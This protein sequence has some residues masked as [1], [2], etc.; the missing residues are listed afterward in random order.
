MTSRVTV[1]GVVLLSLCSC[2]SST[3]RQDDPFS[4]VSEALRS[5][6]RF[7]QARQFDAFLR[8][9]LASEERQNL[10]KDCRENAPS[11]IFCFSVAREKKLRSF[12]E[13]EERA[14][15]PVFR[16]K[17]EP[18]TPELAAGK[19]KNWRAMQKASLKALL[20]GMRSFS[21]DELKATGKFALS[22]SE[23]PNHIAVATAA[24]LEIHLPFE[25]V[26][27]QI[28]RLYEKGARCTKR[29]TANHEHYLTR[30]ALFLFA[31]KKYA[32]AEKLL[33]RVEPVDAYSGRSL[34]W[35]YRSRIALGKKAQADQT[36][37]RLRT[38]FPLA[39]HSLLVTTAV[40]SLS[41]REV[42]P[43]TLPT[44]TDDASLNALI[45]QAECLNE[46]G[47]Q[48]TSSKIVSW[49]L[50]Q[51]TP[52]DPT[53]RAYLASLGDASQQVRTVQNILLTRPALRTPTY[54]KLA[55]PRAFFE[56]FSEFESK[57]DPYLLLAVARKE[58]TLNP[59]AVSPANA[60]GLLQINPDTAKR[61]SGKET[62]DLF[63]P[64]VNTELAARY[65]AEL[66]EVMKGQ[67]PLMIASYNAG[68]Q[69]VAHWTQRYPTND[70]VLFIDLIPYRETRDYVGFVLSNYF[71][72]KRLYSTKAEQLFAD[73]S[74][75]SLAK[76]EEPRGVRSIKSLVDEALQTSES[77]QEEDPSTPFIN[78]WKEL[79]TPRP[80]N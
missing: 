62:S 48:R 65:W 17:P 66:R 54:F 70:L 12:L 46:M 27:S 33:K 29:R 78:K 38:Q 49:A 4:E 64:R 50:G 41:Q 5:T 72:Y 79:D 76:V 36:L 30:A 19:I 21:L 20:S 67:L 23:C 13:K 57:V 2:L 42:A 60:Q 26:S 37:Q 32:A 77:W 18:I 45:E 52:R 71:W 59:K 75:T 16:Q 9:E 31:E 1:L 44:R 43:S 58:S 40:E 69:T 55:Y 22:R 35:L 25:N 11:N 61:L 7:Q 74:S 51:Y 80:A 6:P 73:L 10:Q 24:L 34:Y 14:A 8:E 53:I 15:E 47:F 68:E 63:D 39:F 28:A 3:P 56:L